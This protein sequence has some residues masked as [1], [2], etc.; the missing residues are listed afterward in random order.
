[1][2]Y[3]IVRCEELKE[4]EAFLLEHGEAYVPAVSKN[5]VLFFQDA[6]GG[7]YLNISHRK[8]PVMDRKELLDR[9][10]EVYPDHPI[11][12]LRACEAVLKKVWK[13]GGSPSFRR[14]LKP[15]KA[16]SCI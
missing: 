15:V 3:V 10:Y 12:K 11:L 1:M 9:C 6:Y 14:Y 7:R 13:R 2:K 8:L 4:E 5:T 16:E